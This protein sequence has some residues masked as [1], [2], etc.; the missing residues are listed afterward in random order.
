MF[1]VLCDKALENGGALK[2][3]VT[4]LLDEFANQKIPNFQH[5][6]LITDK[7][8]NNPISASDTF[9]DIRS[10][11]TNGITK[12]VNDLCQRGKAFILKTAFPDLFPD[13]F[14]RIHLRC[15]G[16]NVKQYNVNRYLERFGFMPG[17]A[18]AAQQNH[19]FRIL[20]GKLLE[21]DIHAHCVA[22]RQDQEA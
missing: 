9:N 8:I 21:K 11:R 15:V 12:A 17:S 1:N 2:T 13:L 19:L 16:R 14:N 7:T 5:L 20:L 4:C 3:H 18:I 10:Q 22:I 6:I